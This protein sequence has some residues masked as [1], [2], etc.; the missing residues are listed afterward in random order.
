MYT[1]E[2][3]KKPLCILMTT[4]KPKHNRRKNF[5]AIPFV[6]QILLGTLANATI[7]S[8][9]VLGAVMAKEIFYISVDTVWTLHEFTGGEG[10]IE[11]GFAH[12]DLSIT[13]IAEHLDVVF[14]N[15]ADRIKRERLG[16]PVRRVGAFNGILGTEVLNEGKKI[17]TPIRFTIHDGSELNFWTRN[18]GDAALTTGGIVDIAGTMFGRW[19]H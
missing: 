6:S 7:I 9:G 19:S 12:S 2:V 3:A 1:Y 14:N 18:I 10:P 15:P 8:S 11:V 4:K 5:Q 13:E 16:R 17:R